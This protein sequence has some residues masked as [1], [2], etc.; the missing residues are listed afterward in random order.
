MLSHATTMCEVFWPKL[1]Y[2]RRRTS[3]RRRVS[4]I[5][6]GSALSDSVILKKSWNLRIQLFQI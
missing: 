6:N 2:H 4:L 1:V 3:E 5:P